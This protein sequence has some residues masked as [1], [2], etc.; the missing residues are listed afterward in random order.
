MSVRSFL[1][2][3]FA[4][5][6]SVAPLTALLD[7][8]RPEILPRAELRAAMGDLLEH[9]LIIEILH[10]MVEIRHVPGDREAFNAAIKSSLTSLGEA[11]YLHGDCA[12]FAAAV[13]DHRGLSDQAI[14]CLAVDG[15]P[16][17]CVVKI[18]EDTCV[19][20][21]GTYTERRLIEKYGSDGRSA[22]ITYNPIAVF[23]TKQQEH[24][25]DLAWKYMQYLSRGGVARRFP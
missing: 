19:D 17:H 21:S 23:K 15:E 3:I 14:G 5:R 6:P 7:Q 9:R 12:Y 24:A 25:Y 20:C 8:P 11:L 4:P 2:S 22:A 13:R 18:G 10:R 1:R 16:S